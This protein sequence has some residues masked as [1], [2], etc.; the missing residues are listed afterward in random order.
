MICKILLNLCHTPCHKKTLSSRW[1]SASSPLFILTLLFSCAWVNCAWA[2]TKPEITIDG[3]PAILRDNIRQYLAIAN[4]KCSTPLWRLQSLLGEGQEEIELAAQ[5]VGYYSLTFT[6]KLTQ[7]DDCWQLDIQLTP[8]EPVKITELNLLIRGDGE[9]DSA[10]KEVNE[11]SEIKLGNRLH[12]G[13]YENL[14]SRI[15]NMASS[16]GYYDG[17]FEVAKITVNPAD[18]TAAI[19]LIYDS[20]TRY[21]FGEIR[22]SHNI[23]SEDFLRRYLNF[24]SGDHY[25]T[26]KL[27][28]LK[29]LYNASNYFNVATA[30]PD[31]QHLKN[32]EVPIDVVLEERKRHAYSFGV[33]VATDTG[34]RFLLGFEDYYFNDS[35]HTIK[36]DLSTSKVKSNT[37]ITYTMPMKRPSYEFLKFYTGFEREDVEATSSKNQKLGTSYT[38][39]QDKW[40]QTYAL[41]FENETSSISDVPIDTTNLIIPSITLSRTKTDAQPYPLEGWRFLSRLSGSPKSLG[42]DLSYLQFYTQAK[43]IHSLPVG[44]LIL[45]TELGA[46]KVNDFD[47]LPVSKRFVAGGDASVRGYDY[48]SLGPLEP[49]DPNDLDKERKVIGGNN[50]LVAS[51]E[52]DFLV[53][54]KWAL[55]TFYDIGNAADDRELEPKRA[56]GVGVRWISPIGPVRL[57]IARALD[58]Q[59]GWHFHITMGPD[60]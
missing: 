22:I 13:E 32:Y 10:F 29:N 49:V 56:L 7:K 14:K 20:G 35:G 1:P 50:L 43:Y 28:E 5:A 60:L 15:I 48:K 38:Y 53:R 3:G 21:R 25:D 57:D 51:V 30:S 19:Q 23:L 27:L 58:N 11:N 59:K 18:N 12:H 46:T 42:S 36:A 31:I 24:E 8:G 9:N 26:D 44:R 40:L 54:P 52:Y 17:R 16:R 33:G 41:D 55:A 45:R 47:K 4:E 34:P 2:K 39:Y 37:L 6:T